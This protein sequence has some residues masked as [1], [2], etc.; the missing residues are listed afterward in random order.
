MAIVITDITINKILPLFDDKLSSLSRV[1]TI[2][3]YIAIKIW[4][5]QNKMNS[6]KALKSN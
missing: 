3:C 4:S 1:K 6:Q 2:I 5:M